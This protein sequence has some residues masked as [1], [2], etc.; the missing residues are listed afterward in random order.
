[1]KKGRNAS[2][3]PIP[4]RDGAGMPDQAREYECQPLSVHKKTTD[5]D[6]SFA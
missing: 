4:G 1:M 2:C 6:A 3:P 5:S